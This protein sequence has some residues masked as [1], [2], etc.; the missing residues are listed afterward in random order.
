LKAAADAKREAEEVQQRK[1]TEK[2]AE[3]EAALK[4]A[5]DAKREAEEAQRR[6]EAEKLAEKEAAL[7]AAADA[8]REAEEARQHKAA[9]KLAK[10][11]AALKAAADAKR[12]EEEARRRKEA[13][14]LAKKEAELKSAAEAKREVE[15]ETVTDTK[16]GIEKGGYDCS[17]ELFDGEV[18]LKIKPSVDYK[19]I[20]LF[21]KYL[22]AVDNLKIVLYGWSEDEGNM[23]SISL[24]EP[25]ALGNILSEIPMVEQVYKKN[26]KVVVVLKTHG[27]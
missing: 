6:K 21:K 13:E 27:V 25:L 17:S 2:L 11:E 4:A 3:K 10:K 18:E 14:K 16:K 15:R 19:Q 24:Q 7:K 26:K 9:E 20:N 22:K 5:A 8:K 23:I 1:E 12:E